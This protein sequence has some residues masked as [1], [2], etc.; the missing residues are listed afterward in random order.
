MKKKLLNRFVYI[1]LPKVITKTLKIM[2]GNFPS[3][4]KIRKGIFMIRGTVFCLFL[5]IILPFIN[6]C[7]KESDFFPD[8]VSINFKVYDERDS[9]VT[10]AKISIY[11]SYQSYLSG[12]A[13]L[14]M[15]FS[16]DSAISSPGGA[17]FSLKAQT[18]YWILTTYDDPVRLLKLSNITISSQLDK[19]E[20]SSKVNAR[21]KIAPSN[22]NIA[23]WT[24][25]TNPVPIT[26][27]FN[28]LTDSIVSPIAS[29]P[30]APSSPGA[31]NFSVQAGTYSYYAKG[32]RNCLWTGSVKVGNGGF[33]AVQLSTC[34]TGQI[35]FY[36][37]Q[38]TAIP[39]TYPIK[40]VLD[41]NTANPG[42]I[43]NPATTSPY[44]CGSAL[45]PNALNIY[46]DPNTYTYVAQT[47]DQRCT[48]TGT[49]TLPANG[50]IS[51]Q[52][53]LCP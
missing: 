21:I 17:T 28:S 35:T 43:S 13:S 39:N 16:I 37:P 1:N 20:K 8:N 49:F 34:N 53:P 11:D 41:N 9:L 22:S 33:K 48:W 14:N 38:S 2:F 47:A 31:L 3:Y 10:G 44:L 23:F 15:G 51:I 18:D 40:I 6:S 25:A 19:M 30:I 24:D 12:V 7:K 29:A 32:P 46:T 45:D 36:T 52:L 42:F 50:C 5:L 4:L 27:I 26:V